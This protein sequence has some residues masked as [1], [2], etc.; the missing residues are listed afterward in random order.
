M[1]ILIGT[2]NVSAIQ[3]RRRAHARIELEAR[4]GGG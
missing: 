3:D 1:T 4:E 2:M